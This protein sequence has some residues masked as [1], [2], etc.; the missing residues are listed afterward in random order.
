MDTFRSAVLRR[1]SRLPSDGGW[2]HVNEW[3]SPAP[4]VTVV[5]AH[6]WGLSSRSW[7]D[8]AQLL[9]LSDP[10]LRVIAY[11]HRGHGGSASAPATIER[12][13]DDLAA[14]LRAHVPDG[15]IVLGGHSLGGMTV[16]A[17]AER[18]PEVIADRVGGVAFVATSAGDLLGSIR[19]IRGVNRILHAGLVV[20]PLLKT[21][22]RPLFLVRQAVRGG[23]GARPR[24]RDMNRSVRQAAHA[25]PRAVA[26]LGRSLLL[27]QLYHSLERFR[28]I[29]VVTMAGTKDKLTPPAHARRIADLLPGSQ[30]VVF[31]GAGHFLPYERR[32]AV[33]AHLLDLT[34]K[35]RASARRPAGAM[36]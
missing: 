1:Q 4:D 7:E 17:L 35:A 19:S 12:L 26:S 27:H 18:Y 11:D 24:R 9:V 8:V 13:A 14:V 15:P 30:I 23:F 31:P 29:D 32:E 6:G 36:A 33:A 5:L 21:P 16:M 3:G 34:A 28:S 22:E 25:D 2:L 20:M 10:T